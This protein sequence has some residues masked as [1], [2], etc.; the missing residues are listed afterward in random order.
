MPDLARGA[1][2]LG[3]GG[4]GDP[5]LGRLLAE[6]ALREHGPVPLVRPEDLPDD[7]CV[8]PVAQMGAPTVS[9]EKLP[10]YAEIGRAV[11]TL[12]EHLGRTPTHV[13][14]IEA[15][16][17]NSTLPVA[18]AALLGLPL[19]DGDG[20]GRAFPELQ[21]V[22]P[23]IAGVPATPM[24]ITDEQ[25]NTGVLT[26]PTAKWAEDLARSMTITMGCTAIIAN[27]PMTGA[28][29]RET[30]IGGTLGLCVRIG[31]AIAAARA[32]LDDPVAAVATETGGTVLHTGKVVDVARR[33]TTGFARGEARITGDGGD[34]L[35]RFQN[36]HLL[37][38]VDGRIVTTTPDL[39]MVL[40][41]ATGEPVT[42]EALRFGHRVSVLGAPADPRWHTP[43][44]LAVVGPRYFGYDTDPVRVGAPG[45]TA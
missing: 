34:C 28:Q 18:G 24:S 21:M 20:M 25:G 6:Q 12:A 23:G 38:E 17:I 30:L 15:G 8:L 4:G 31:R 37:A 1:A 5:Y 40:D 10:A 3:T 19:V 42:T 44:A 11:T 45:G 29:A 32:G 26:C 7:A 22:L 43:A 41:T 35:L 39:I 14:C 2:V 13:A 16:G 27:Y 33:T 36:E 9:V